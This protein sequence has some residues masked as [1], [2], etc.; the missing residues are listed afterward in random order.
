MVFLLPLSRTG[1]TMTRK[2]T[3]KNLSLSL[4]P[5]DFVVYVTYPNNSKE[6]PYL[7]NLP[8]I[9]QGDTLIGNNDTKVTVVRTAEF[10][11]NARIFIKPLPNPTKVAAKAR[12]EAITAEL[13]QIE[14]E[15]R[16]AAYYAE[17]ARKSPKAKLLVTEW[18]KLQKVLNS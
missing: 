18:L 9:K 3:R 10:D 6:Y 12:C 8:G 7:C 15:L 2:Y 11:G 17:L 13:K 14:F 1:P 16:K 5:K 4:F